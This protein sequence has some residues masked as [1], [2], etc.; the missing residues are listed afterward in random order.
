VHSS[1]FDEAP[2]EALTIED[3]AGERLWDPLTLG[4]DHL[5]LFSG[6]TTGRAE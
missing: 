3:V 1:G 5:D 6:W 2:T 4:G